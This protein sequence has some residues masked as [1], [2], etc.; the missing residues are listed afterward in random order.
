MKIILSFLM[1]VGLGFCSL[2]MA[3]EVN[4]LQ[5]SDTN[6]SVEEVYQNYIIYDEEGNFL[7]E[8]RGVALGDII[9][10]KNF[11]KYEV[12]YLDDDI[13]I[14]FCAECN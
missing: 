9:I 7:T 14:P 10:D 8:K 13:Y 4:N 11:S 5:E 12:V 6:V 2:P 3:L 1:A